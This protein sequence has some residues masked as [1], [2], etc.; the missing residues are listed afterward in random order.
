MLPLRKHG[1]R[2]PHLQPCVTCFDCQISLDT[3]K[4]RQVGQGI[5]ALELPHSDID[6]DKLRQVGQGI[7]ALEL[8]SA[9]SGAADRRTRC[10]A[11]N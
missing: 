7:A 10:L 4:L 6:T 1:L 11:G 5:A 2:T 9:E 8:L 3:D